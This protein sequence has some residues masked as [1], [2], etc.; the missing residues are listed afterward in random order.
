MSYADKLKRP[1][2]QRKRLQILERANWKCEQCG[3]KESML[4]V[5]H[6]QYISGRDPW[7]YKDNQ[8]VALCAMCH[9]AQHHARDDLLEIIASLDLDG[10]NSRDYA[11]F[12][13]AGFF[14]FD[15]G[16]KMQ[17]S[18]LLVEVGQQAR[19]RFDSLLRQELGEDDEILRS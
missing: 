18:R 3:E 16:P 4:H 8:L 13:L 15:V 1:E 17:A 5:H 11:A 6:K 19:E 9:A 14:G 2:W 12:L 10:P 7:E